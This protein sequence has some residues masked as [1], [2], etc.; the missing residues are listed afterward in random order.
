LIINKLCELR[1]LCVKQKIGKAKSEKRRFSLF[2][3]LNYLDRNQ[4]QD[5]NL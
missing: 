1:G 5:S 3:Q 4:E 2:Y